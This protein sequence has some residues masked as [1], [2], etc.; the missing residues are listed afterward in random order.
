V[1]IAS[2]SSPAR[3][4][5]PTVVLVLLAVATPLLGQ[6]RARIERTTSFHATADGT[7]LGEIRAG[8][9]VVLGPRQ[10]NW[11]Q[12]VFESWIFSASIDPVREAGFTHRVSQA[13]GENLRASP[14]GALTGRA[15]EG[16]FWTRIRS[17]GGWSRVRREVWISNAALAQAAPAQR[18]VASVETPPTPALQPAVPPGAP[19]ERVIVR[20][21]A[22]LSTGPGMDE[23]GK[24]PEPM[25]AEVLQRTGGWVK[26]RTET[27]VREG[28]VS[29][30][31]ADSSQLTLSQLI[32][33]PDKYL[34]VR[35]TWRLQY[36]SSHVAD[37]LRPELPA[38]EPY[39]LT[40]GP[41]P[42]A[43]F[44]YLSVTKPQAE[45]FRSLQPL[46]EIVVRATILAARTR[47]LPIPVLRYE[48][49]P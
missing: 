43:G 33:T 42:E 2:Q 31:P 26:I 20:T 23:V 17:Q 16:V 9:Q 45:R 15:L 4:R 38:G 30:A 39:L 12:I 14:N 18:P 35:V 32:E 49:T 27:W 36:I 28:D 41:L 7:R 22:L 1:R 34:G 40:R 6:S 3:G 13:N 37:E 25:A 21:G 10:G 47:Y 5:L 8:Q 46:E 19:V 48:A 29:P 24:L 44:V 11:R